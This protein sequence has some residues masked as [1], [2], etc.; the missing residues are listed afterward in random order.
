MC[1][2]SYVS[3]VPCNFHMSCVTYHMSQYFGL[4]KKIC[5]QI[6]WSLSLEGLLSTGPSLWLQQQLFPSFYK[7]RQLFLIMSAISYVTLFGTWLICAIHWILYTTLASKETPLWVVHKWC[8]APK[9]GRLAVGQFLFVPQILA[10]LF[11]FF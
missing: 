9:S 5:Q 3:Y 11:L 6:W 10:N 4:N 1:H 7:S 2:V 8:H